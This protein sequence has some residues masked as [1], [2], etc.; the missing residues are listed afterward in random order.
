MYSVNVDDSKRI[1]VSGGKHQVSYAVDGSLMNPLEA[2]Y[3]VLASCAAVYAKKECKAMGVSAAGIRIGCRPFA[4][5]G[6]PLTL[7]RFR[8]EVS[9]PE[10]FSTEQRERVLQAINECAVK[11]IVQTGADIAFS[12]SETPVTVA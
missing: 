8:T 10:S 5:H 2:F 4:G 7:S 3:A 11:K 12:V 6:G 1:T 9:F